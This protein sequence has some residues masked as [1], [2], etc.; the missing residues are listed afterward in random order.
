M[1]KSRE[2]LTA[3]Q[4]NKTSIYEIK[5]RKRESER[6]IKTQQYYIIYIYNKIS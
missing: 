1:K 4:L 6:K 5:E 3:K 2:L